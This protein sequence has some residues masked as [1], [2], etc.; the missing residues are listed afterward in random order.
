M[1]YP[2]PCHQHRQDGL[3]TESHTRTCPLTGLQNVQHDSMQRCVAK[4]ICGR[5]GHVSGV[6]TKQ[7]FPFLQSELGQPPRAR[8]LEMDIVIP[9]DALQLADDSAWAGKALLV[10]ITLSEPTAGTHVRRAAATALATACSA[11]RRKREHYGDPTLEGDLPL[12]YDPAV[13]HLVPFA[14]EMYGALGPSAQLFIQNLARHIAGG[15][16]QLDLAVYACVMRTIRTTLAVEL[17]R[18]LAWRSLRHQVLAGSVPARPAR[19]PG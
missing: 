16:E 19:S 10:D 15:P 2:R 3:L 12:T 4:D 11:E 18:S 8:P 13:Y 5:L 6:L 9:R 7:T 14:V 17:Q 1:S